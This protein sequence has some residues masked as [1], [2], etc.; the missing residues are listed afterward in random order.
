M[1]WVENYLWLIV[2][3]PF[4]G[5]TWTLW[6]RWTVWTLD[7]RFRGGDVPPSRE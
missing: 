5:V 3:L 2:I 1:E 4:A 6:T 7:P